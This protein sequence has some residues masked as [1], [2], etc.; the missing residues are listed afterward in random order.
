MHFILVVEDDPVARRLLMS[1]LATAGY[2]V[3]APGSYME[4][5]G[6]IGTRKPDLLLLDV[7]APERYG[8]SFVRL[9]RR[10]GWDG[11]VVMLSNRADWQAISREIQVEFGL[12]KPLDIDDLISRITALLPRAKPAPRAKPG[13]AGSTPRSRAF[14]RRRSG[15][16]P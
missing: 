14:R 16:R 1:V 6:L 11:Q 3:E 15:S 10:V 13:R 9:A 8:A 12:G 5:L 2:E 7:S 4:A